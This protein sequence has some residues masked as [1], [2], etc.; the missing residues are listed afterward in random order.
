MRVRL[1]EMKEEAANTFT[2]CGSA[3][4]ERIKDTANLLLHFI[5]H[6]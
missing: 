2:F 3:D 5:T 4:V 6:E 1:G